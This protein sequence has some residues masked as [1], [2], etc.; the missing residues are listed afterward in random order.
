MD[1][2][3]MKP[4]KRPCLRCGRVFASRDLFTNR[5]CPPCD[6]ANARD[7]DRAPPASSAVYV[8]GR[9]VSFSED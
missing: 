4:G 6:R 9:R 8:N 2:P 5:I 1:G 3:P 7:R